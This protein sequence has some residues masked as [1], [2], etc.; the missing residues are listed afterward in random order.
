MT[1][2]T[3]RYKFHGP[4]S[5]QVGIDHLH[6]IAD[7][8][9]EYFDNGIVAGDDVVSFVN[10]TL[11][12]TAEDDIALL[13]TDIELYGEGLFDLVFT[14]TP[15][16]RIAIETLIPQEGLT[17]E[18]CKNLNNLILKDRKN[19]WIFFGKTGH[20]LI[21][22]LSEPIIRRFITRLNL[23]KRIAFT[24]A[25]GAAYAVNQEFNTRVRV[26]MRNARY[27]ASPVREKFVAEMIE[28]LKSNVMIQEETII[29]CLVFIL[30]LFDEIGQDYKIYSMISEKKRTFVSLLADA[31]N[32]NEFVGRYSMEYLM[33]QRIQRPVVDP[34]D[35]RKKI[36]LADLI[37]MSVYGIPAD[38]CTPERTEPNGSFKS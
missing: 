5:G 2:P 35:M 38:S 15:Q 34:D 10:S 18:A 12:I 7:T 11:G 30:E 4:E 31:A 23:H 3:E 37:C 29:D 9:N 36:Y 6:A 33:S 24:A 32:F 26:I 25:T 22:D 1:V 27:T 19:T 20:S 28:R 8:I 16:L 14:P 13:L 17:D 21:V